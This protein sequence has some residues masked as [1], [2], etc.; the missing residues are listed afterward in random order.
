MGLPF[1]PA[2]TGWAQDQ[3]SIGR[4][5]HKDLKLTE[6]SLGPIQTRLEAFLGF[7]IKNESLHK[8]NCCNVLSDCC[9]EVC[10]AIQRRFPAAT[11]AEVRLW[12]R[13]GILKKTS[14]SKIIITPL[15]RPRLD[16]RECVT[17]II[18]QELLV[19][20]AWRGWRGGPQLNISLRFF[21]F[22]KIFFS[23][24]SW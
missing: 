15:P 22:S 23:Q 11:G 10:S 4:R 17:S 3:L 12:T 20:F 5:P 18:F 21:L 1:S 14:F 6:L 9:Q 13:S 24:T 7:L 16:L 8:T 19:F 2:Y